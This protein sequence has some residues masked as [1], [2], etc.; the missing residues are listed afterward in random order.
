MRRVGLLLFCGLLLPL[1]VTASA[2]AQGAVVELTPKSGPPGSVVNI[3]GAG[4]TA[5]NDPVGAPQIRFSTRDAEPEKPVTVVQGAFS[6]SLPI[7][8]G[9]APGEYLVIV[10]QQT[11]RGAHVFGTPGRARFRVT[12][13]AAAAAAAPSRSASQATVAVGSV[14]V[15]LLLLAGGAAALHRRTS[16][17]PLG[18]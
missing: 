5:P 10:T 11:S 18:S 17:R 3:T 15:A 12:A 4:F 9:M 16:H 14:M 7:P 13:G 2:S 8:A 6:D 1:I